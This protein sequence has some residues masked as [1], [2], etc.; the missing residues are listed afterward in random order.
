MDSI[1]PIK[2]AEAGDTRGI[3]IACRLDS[4]QAIDVVQF[5]TDWL[6]ERKEKV[7]FE[8]RI[9]NK[10]ISHFRRNL[11]E[12]NL[13][14]TKFILSVGGDGTVLR[15]AQSLP[16]RN[17]P[18]IL[19]VNLGSVGFLDE[20][21]R[22]TLQYDLEKI[23]LGKYILVKSA[24]LSTYVEGQRLSDA[25]NEVL[26][27]SS[28]PSKVLYVNISIDGSHFTQSYLDGLIISTNTG[29]TAYALSAG[30]IMVDPRLESFEIVPLNPFVG[31]GQF[32]PLL[33]PSFSEIT[34]ELLRPRLN[35]IIVVDGQIEYK[36]NP[37]ATLKLRRSESDIHFIRFK[38]NVHANY[39]DKVR[40][41]ILFNRKLA[42]D[43]LET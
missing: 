36:I 8:T 13:E 40:E 32:R 29:S 25:L 27:L 5:I 9:A 42:D 23:F 16:K 21:E 11:D 12:M 37:R 24:R 41:K 35:G 14:N 34:V 28:K 1:P 39:Y 3:G 6:L 10:F 4:P 22:D 26:V 7:F 2:S 31:T 18:P 15:V 20:S 30:G 17:T 19:G 38:D 33:V 43:S